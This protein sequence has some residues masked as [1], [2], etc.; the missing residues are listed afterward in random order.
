MKQIQI[1]FFDN[2]KQIFNTYN[3][4]YENM[5]QEYK[6]KIFKLNSAIEEILS[7]VIIIY[8]SLWRRCLCIRKIR[9]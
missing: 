8:L 5:E 7:T 3:T 9:K 4:F 2:L 6:Q 1:V